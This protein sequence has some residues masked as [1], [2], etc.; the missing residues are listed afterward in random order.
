MVATASAEL[1]RT[2]KRKEKNG[3]KTEEDAVDAKPSAEKSHG[4]SKHAR[5]SHGRLKCHA[6]QSTEHRIKECDVFQKA[7]KIIGNNRHKK[8]L[9][10]VAR[11]EDE[12]V[13]DNFVFVS[14][15]EDEDIS[16]TEEIAVIAESTMMALP[17]KRNVKLHDCDVVLDSAATVGVFY[18]ARLLT[19]LRH[20]TRPVRVGGLNKNGA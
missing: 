15:T 17:G 13:D 11:D 3:T 12:I 2:K 10:A 18:N 1:K 19:N 6:C 14:T 7:L 5:P 8:E 9:A 16:S 20:A 4:G